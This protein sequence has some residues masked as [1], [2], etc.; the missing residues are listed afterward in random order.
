MPPVDVAIIG[1]GSIGIAVA[2]YLVRDHGVRSL[3][4]IDPLQPMSL[5]SAQSGEN[6]RNWWPRRTCASVSPPRAPS[7]WRARRRTSPHIWPPR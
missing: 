5:T 2:Y 3:A 4:L 7:R 6:Y 1:T